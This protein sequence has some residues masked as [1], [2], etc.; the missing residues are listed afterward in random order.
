MNR[1]RI[2]DVMAFSL[3]LPFLAVTVPPTLSQSREKIHRARCVSNLKTLWSAF[4]AFTKEH[5]EH[6]PAAGWCGRDAEHDWTWGGNIISV[7]QRDPAA[8]RRIRIEEGSIWSYMT[9]MKRVGPY[10]GGTRGPKDEWYTD[11]AENIY[12]CPTAGPVGKK[13]GLSYSMNYRLED[14]PGGQTVDIIGLKLS[15]IKNPA[16]IILLVEETELTIND[17]C[18][19]V[20]GQENDI[21]DLALKHADGGHLLFCDGHIGWIHKVEL[22]KLMNADSAHFRPELQ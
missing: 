22:L 19:I 5:D 18:F 15:Q 3:L 4:L 7:P 13:R 12:L 14:P 2:L 8:C 9:G 17:G 21:P 16:E 1:T 20:T 11:A 10:G 6:L